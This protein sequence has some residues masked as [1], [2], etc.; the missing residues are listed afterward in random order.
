MPHVVFLHGLESSVDAHGVPSGGKARY[1]AGAFDA[2]LVALDTSAAQA[3]AA[4]VWAATGGWSY[5]FDGYEDAFAVPLARA[6]A[7]VQA[8]PDVVVASSFGG[9]VALRLLHEG[10]DFRGRLILLAGAGPK[11]TPWRTLP[12]GVAALL[13]HGTRD[14]VVPLEHSEALAATS[15]DATFLPV[16]DDH[17]LASV[18]HDEQLGRWVREGW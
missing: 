18:V 1:L 5:P 8:G 11:L 17:R 3:V 16:D 6:R 2:V 14:D 9:A 12:A 13:V 15:P 10:W 4:R 7:A